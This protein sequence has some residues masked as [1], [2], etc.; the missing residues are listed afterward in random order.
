[1]KEAKRELYPSDLT[2]AQWEFIKTLL[3]LD[4]NTGRARNDDREVINGILGDVLILLD[5]AVFAHANS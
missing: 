5:Q 1:M 4:A 3:P 2:D